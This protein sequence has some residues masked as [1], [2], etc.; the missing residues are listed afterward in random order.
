MN[1]FYYEGKSNLTQRLTGLVQHDQVKDEIIKQQGLPLLFRCSIEPELVE[2]AE[3]NHRSL[4]IMLALTFNQEGFDAMKSNTEFIRHLKTLLNSTDDEAKRAAE[5]ILWKIEQ[6]EQAVGKAI[7]PSNDKYDIMLSYSH[8][9]KELCHYIYERLI[10]DGY[11]VWLDRDQMHG[12]PMDAMADAIE[13]SEYVLLCMSDAYKQSPYCQLEAH[14]AFQRRCRLIPL[15]MT[16]RYKPDGWLGIM[17]SGK[18]YVDFPKL[19]SEAA[20]LVLKKE[21]DEQ[22]KRSTLV[23]AVPQQQPTSITSSAPNVSVVPVDISTT[24]QSRR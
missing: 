14:Y 16:P 9:N 8:S 11:R 19:S 23:K 15:V 1:P 4:E 10:Q 7:I 21:I 18:I 22:R 24:Q 20:Y 13:N 5:R 2:C 12:A 3:R 17:T 6:G